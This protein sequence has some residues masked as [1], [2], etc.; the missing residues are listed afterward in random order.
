[1]S[2]VKE[3]DG[4]RGIAAMV[5]VLYHVTNDGFAWGW[6]AVDLFFVLSGYLI[7]AIVLKHGES[8][9]FLMSFYAAGACE[10]GRSI[11]C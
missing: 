8:P 5:I 6:A 2:R 4:L 11:T 9:T 7:T 1:M 3:L 10:S